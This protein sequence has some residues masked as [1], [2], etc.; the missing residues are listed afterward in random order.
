MT[1]AIGIWS[2]HHIWMNTKRRHNIKT[3]VIFS[4]SFTANGTI[5]LYCITMIKCFIRFYLVSFLWVFGHKDVVLGQRLKELFTFV[6]TISTGMPRLCVSVFSP[7]GSTTASSSPAVGAR[8]CGE[9]GLASSG[10]VYSWNA[11]TTS[12]KTKG[13]KDR[14]SDH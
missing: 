2:W 14:N 8:L 12:G 10:S 13:I 9:D 3:T 1:T 7:S 6:Q 4:S 11:F 5:L